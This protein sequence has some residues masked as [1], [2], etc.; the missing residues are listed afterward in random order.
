MNKQTESISNFNTSNNISIATIK[1]MTT[2]NQMN[3]NNFNASAI[4]SF[5]YATNSFIVKL[6]EL[7]VFMNLTLRK[8]AASIG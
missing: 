4:L 3:L 1:P 7:V 2:Y 8:L 6:L 5:Y